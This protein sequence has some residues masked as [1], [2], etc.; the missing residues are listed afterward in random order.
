MYVL[1]VLV[2]TSWLHNVWEMFLLFIKFK[3]LWKNGIPEKIKAHLTQHPKHCN[4]CWSP[5]F[6]TLFKNILAPP[7]FRKEGRDSAFY[8]RP[9]KAETV[10]TFEEKWKI[11]LKLI[12]LLFQVTFIFLTQIY[13]NM[14]LIISSSNF[15][16][17]LT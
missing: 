11:I 7:P 1:S 9:S 16:T 15:I 4:N 5:T 3:F 6:L 13:C 12:Y 10:T 8:M 14:N 17:W 2:V